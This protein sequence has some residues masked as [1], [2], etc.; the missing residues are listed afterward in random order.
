MEGGGGE[1]ERQ[2]ELWLPPQ[3]ARALATRE[4]GAQAQARGVDETKARQSGPL[5]FD[6][7]FGDAVSC[8]QP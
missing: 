5:A 6:V 1:R 3:R 4:T 2:V 7:D 8:E